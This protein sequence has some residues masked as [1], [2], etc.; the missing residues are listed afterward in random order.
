MTITITL[1]NFEMTAPSQSAL[2]AGW[3]WVNATDKQ[4]IVNFCS[5]NG[6]QLAEGDELVDEWMEIAAIT[7]ANAS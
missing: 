5:A 7:K 3:D 6:E 4:E 2:D 1:A